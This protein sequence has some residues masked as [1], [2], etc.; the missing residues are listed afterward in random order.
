MAHCRVSVL[1]R[2]MLFNRLEYAVFFVVVFTVYWS[3]VRLRR[4]PTFFLLAASYSSMRA[5]TRFLLLIFALDGDDY[6]LA[7]WL[8]TDRRA[9]AAQACWP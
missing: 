9:A 5:G 3:T 7:A 1:G 4:F 8:S 6:G 2:G